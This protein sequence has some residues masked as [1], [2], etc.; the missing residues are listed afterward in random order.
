MTRTARCCCRACEVVVEGDP[1]INAVCHCGNCKRRTGSAFGWSVYFGDPQIMS[2]TG[3]LRLYEN[4]ARGQTRSF[5][6]ACGTTLFWVSEDAPG[7]TGFAGGCFENPPIPE[8]NTRAE[9]D[10][11]CPWVNLPENW[12]VWPSRD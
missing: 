8:P 2:V 9:P 6:A 10:Q 7:V 3:D 1:F 12:A 4:P 5:C 11:R